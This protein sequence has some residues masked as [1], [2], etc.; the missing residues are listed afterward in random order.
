MGRVIFE[1]GGP[2]EIRPEVAKEALRLAS[3]KLPVPTEFVTLASPPRIGNKTVEPAASVPTTTTTTT[4]AAAAAAASAPI[5]AGEASAIA[6]S[7]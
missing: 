6:T 1:I 4:T 3:A 2:V 5:A 7:S